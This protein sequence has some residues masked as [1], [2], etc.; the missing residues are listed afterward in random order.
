MKKYR[1]KRYLK[2][3]TLIELLV[4]VAIITVLA[5]ILLPYVTNRVEDSKIAAAEDLISTMRT[6]TLLMFNDTSVFS[7]RWDDLLNNPLVYPNW[8]G[9]YISTR[10]NIG[11][12][13]TTNDTA[14]AGSPW[15][16][17]VILFANNDGAKEWFGATTGGLPQFTK[18]VALGIVNPLVSG[19][20]V[21]PLSSLQKIDQDLDDGIN[22]TG[23]IIYLNITTTPIT[24]TGLAAGSFQAYNANPTTT[25]MLAILLNA[26]P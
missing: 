20:A 16:T 2:G 18:S 8:K 11:T 5:A 24:T 25:T 6:A 12:T 21:I 4:V 23:Y 17:N 10:P 14:L 26:M 3:V 7:I 9:P 19:Q 22:N 1:K 13:N 15:K